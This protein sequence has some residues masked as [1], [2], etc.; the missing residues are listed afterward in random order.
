MK[1]NIYILFIGINNLNQY[2]RENILNVE[3]VTSK[4]NPTKLAHNLALKFSEKIN[5]TEPTP[6]LALKN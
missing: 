2:L 4:H 6:N 5:L 3:F 1:I